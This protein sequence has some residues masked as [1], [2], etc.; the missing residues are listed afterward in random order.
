MAKKIKDYYDLAYA[1]EL[2]Q[3]IQKATAAFDQQRFLDLVKDQ[4]EA[5]EFT[6]RQELLASSIKKSLPLSYPESLVVFEEILGAELEGSLGMFS[7]GYWLWPIGKYVELYGSQEFELSAAFCKELTK[8]FTGEFSMRPLLANFP[9][10]TMALLLDWSKDE[11]KRV[12]RLASECMRIRLPWAKKLTIVLEYFETFK[13]I[14]T[15]LKDEADK[16]IQKSVANNLNDLYKEDEDKFEEII[17]SWQKEEVSAACAWIIKH[18]SRTK[19][20]QNK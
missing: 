19:N 6:Q 9:S 18:G 16:T 2:S 17:S 15:N 3:K 12:R 13:T 10:E 1:E 4:L 7:E 11:N 8:R 14:L 5:L 20:K